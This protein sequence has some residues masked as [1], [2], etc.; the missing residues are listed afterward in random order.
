MTASEI[1][2][3]IAMRFPDAIIEQSAFRGEHT[4][5]VQTGALQD[6]LMFLRD[7]QSLDHLSEIT[8]VDYLGRSPRFDVVYHLF[9]FEN[10]TWYRLKTRVEDKEPVPTTVGLWPCAD[11]AERE[12]WD[13]FGIP[14]EGHP[15]LFR[16]MMPEGWVGHPLRK[17]F[18]MSQITLPRSGATKI[19]E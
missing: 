6:V 4:T 16:I 13:L 18:P 12:I 1:S 5:V 2:A 3:E 15:G 19:P 10:H 14:F 17:D 8:A 9:S 7:D 11:W